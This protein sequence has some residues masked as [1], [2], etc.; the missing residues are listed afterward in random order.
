MSDKRSNDDRYP[1]SIEFRYYDAS[2]EERKNLRKQISDLLAIEEEIIFGVIHGSFNTDS[3]FRDIDIAVYIREPDKDSTYAFTIDFAASLEAELG[4]PIDVQVL[5][6]ASLPFR[7]KVLTDGDLVFCRDHY[8]Y[9]S[10]QNLTI[11]M[12]LDFQV[13]LRYA[14]S[15]R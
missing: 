15:R 2:P 12:Y 6:E 7:Y 9:A 5:N 8:L 10:I 1:P 4:L 3:S 14:Y 13:F 11:R